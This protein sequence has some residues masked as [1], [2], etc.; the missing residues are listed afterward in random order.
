MLIKLGGL[1]LPA[2]EAGCPDLSLLTPEEQDRVWELSRKCRNSLQSVEPGVTPE[3]LREVQGLLAKVPTLRPGEKFAGPRI[4]VPRALNRYWHW[5]R[6]TARA[7]GLAS[8]KQRA[9]IGPVHGDD[10]NIVPRRR[11]ARSLNF[12]GLRQAEGLR[13]RLRSP[14]RS[15]ILRYVLLSLR[16][17]C[18]PACHCTQTYPYGAGSFAAK[19]WGGLFRCPA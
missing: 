19:R 2:I 18:E 3:E 12:E 11:R 14:C 10:C 9:A 7:R 5:V 13:S 16:G 15:R 17:R 1:H 6:P 4:E 8:G